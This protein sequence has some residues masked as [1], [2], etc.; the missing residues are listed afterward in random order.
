MAYLYADTNYNTYCH[1]PKRH[2]ASC[3]MPSSFITCGINTPLPHLKKAVAV[4][5]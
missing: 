3:F 1:I 4:R 5:N 2:R